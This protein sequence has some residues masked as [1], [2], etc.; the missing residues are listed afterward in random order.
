MSHKSKQRNIACV[1]GSTGGRCVCDTKL[2][3]LRN[4][5]RKDTH[6]AVQ[7]GED[8]N[9]Q[10]RYRFHNKNAHRFYDKN[11]HKLEQ[12]RTFTS[13]HNTQDKGQGP[14]SLGPTTVK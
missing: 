3:F 9:I 10:R 13:I 12:S 2:R 1:L 6:D 7:H 14:V 8:N 11:A 5:K 4:S